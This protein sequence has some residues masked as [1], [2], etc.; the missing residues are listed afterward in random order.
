MIL[1]LMISVGLIGANSLVLSP[2]A[3]EVA[4]GVGAERTSDVMT[5]AA[6]YGISVA[7]SALFFAPRADKVGPHKALETGLV[8]ILIGLGFSIAATN[9]TVLSIGQGVVGVGAGMALPAIYSLAAIIS[10]KGQESR[11]MGM[12]LTGWTLSMVGGVTL[13]AYVADLIHWR[14]VFGLL[15][16]GSLVI[17]IVLLKASFPPHTPATKVTS[18]I[19]AVQVPG[20]LPAMFSVLM[21]GTGFYGVYNYLGAH[22]TDALHRNVGAAGWLTLS[23]GLGFGAAMLFDPWLDKVGP[24]LGLL[25]VFSGLSIYYVGMSAWTH[26][27]AMIVALMFGWGVLQH[28][29][30]NLT[31][32]RLSRLDP[33]QRG[34]VM[35][36]NSTTMYASVFAATVL[37]RPGYESFGINLCLWIS[38]ALTLM[39]AA[40]ALWARTSRTLPE[41]SV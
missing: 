27:Y 18:P 16:F 21:L 34:A 8:L 38:A 39:G 11:T 12:V 24:R 23:Y 40:E 3:A 36:L 13:S 25:A 35:G 1:L 26:S 33:S 31:V 19:S 28:L 7:L 9:L 20:I 37:Y 22:L 10:P 32:S 6:I 4:S 41:K 17:L 2:I 29:G 5:A 15:G 30:L 14:A